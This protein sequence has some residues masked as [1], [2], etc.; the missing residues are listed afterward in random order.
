MMLDLPSETEVKA[1]FAHKIVGTRK[2]VL[3]DDHCSGTLPDEMPKVICEAGLTKEKKKAR[4]LSALRSTDKMLT[5][6]QLMHATAMHR[7]GKFYTLLDELVD[8]KQITC[9][10]LPHTKR[11]AYRCA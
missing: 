7:A 2:N 10:R 6:H 4:I 8:A 11:R 9:D 5:A 3:R 1:M